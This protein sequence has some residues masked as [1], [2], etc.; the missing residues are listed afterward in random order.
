MCDGMNTV[1]MVVEEKPWPHSV[2]IAE[3]YSQNMLTKISWKQRN[4]FTKEVIEELISRIFFWWWRISC[5]STLWTKG[6]AATKMLFTTYF[7]VESFAM[8]WKNVICKCMVGMKTFEQKCKLA[9]KLD[10]SSSS[11]SKK[12]GYNC[13]TSKLLFWYS[14]NELK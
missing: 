6:I 4:V 10:Y 14:E 11:I 5:F 9:A 1:F 2:E 8:Y 7:W 13:M 12:L 3:I